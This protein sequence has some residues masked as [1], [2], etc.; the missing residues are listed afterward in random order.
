M[1]MIGRTHRMHGDLRNAYKILV[2]K[3]GKQRP[4]KRPR[5]MTSNM[6][7]T[8]WNVKVLISFKWLRTGLNGELL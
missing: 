4:P 6:T 1:N 2:G 8:Y 5:N 3:L 7:L